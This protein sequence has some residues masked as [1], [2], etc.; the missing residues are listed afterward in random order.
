MLS[1][2]AEGCG[3]G[4]V[5]RRLLGRVDAIRAGQVRLEPATGDRLTALVRSKTNSAMSRAVQAID[6]KYLRTADPAASVEHLIAE[7]REEYIQRSELVD[8]FQAEIDQTDGRMP[9]GG[10]DVHRR[11]R[12]E[13]ESANRA[14]KATAALVAL[15]APAVEEI[16]TALLSFARSQQWHVRSEQGHDLHPQVRSAVGCEVGRVLAAIGDNRAGSLLIAALADPD[17]D[18]RY[19]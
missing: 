6:V 19:T 9:I 8:A 12:A 1:Y 3:L 7:I 15:G 16:V 5:E 4:D 13:I 17:K 11:R 14:G 18:V 10:S 2:V